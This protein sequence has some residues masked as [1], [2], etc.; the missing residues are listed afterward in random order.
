MKISQSSYV[1]Q[2]GTCENTIV[3]TYYPSQTP[4]ITVTQTPTITTTQTP[5]QT[6]TPS[7]TITKLK[8]KL[9]NKQ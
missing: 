4:T 2:V 8:Q 7:V 5:T 9:H 1:S 6:N 3:E